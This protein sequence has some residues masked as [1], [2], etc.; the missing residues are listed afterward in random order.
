[1]E[2]RDILTEIELQVRKAREDFDL[3]AHE[4][5]REH[6]DNLGEFLDNNLTSIS[7]ESGESAESEHSG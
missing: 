1:M 6:L 5:C 4:A 3:A 2:L 7:R